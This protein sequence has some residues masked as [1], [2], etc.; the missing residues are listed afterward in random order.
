MT[1]KAAALELIRQAIEEDQK[2]SYAQAYRLYKSAIATMIH[3]L[4]CRC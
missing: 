2:Q 4:K 1:D 3:A